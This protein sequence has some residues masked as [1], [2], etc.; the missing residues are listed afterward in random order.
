MNSQK[1]IEDCVTSKFP[2]LFESVREIITKSERDFSRDKVLK[3]ESFLWDHT[4]Q[5]CAV[6]QKICLEEGVDP[7]LPVITSLFHDIGKFDKGTYHSGDIP[8]EQL[9]SK[10]AESI[11]IREGMDKKQIHQIT[12]SL[13]TLYNEHKPLTRTAEIVHDSDFLAKS[14][15]MGVAHFFIKSALRGTTLL[16][17]LIQS[18]GRELTYAS[19]LS[20]NMRTRTGKRIAA[21]KKK[22]TLS[23][24]KGLIKEVNHL[25]NIHLKIRKLTWPCPN[26]PQKHIRVFMVLPHRCPEC[27][28][29][30]RTK[31]SSQKGIKCTQLITDIKCNKC[32]WKIQTRFCLPEVCP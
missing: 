21:Q 6:A 25:G 17:S 11:L 30:I 28:G 23:F 24:F 18:S 26:D 19:V 32:S 12:S 7:L 20:Q 3:R 31:N 4:L 2:H 13:E 15:H 5:V 9:S 1:S 16:N 8:E 14:G 27:Q 22:K 10:K 29:D